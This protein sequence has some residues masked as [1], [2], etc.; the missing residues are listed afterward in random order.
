MGYRPAGVP[1]EGHPNLGVHVPV[2]GPGFCF[3]DP[4]G[5]RESRPGCSTD[6]LDQPLSGTQGDAARL[7]GD[8]EPSSLGDTQEGHLDDG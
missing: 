7:Q 2:M 6:A 5:C 4:D 3:G 1:L 8:G